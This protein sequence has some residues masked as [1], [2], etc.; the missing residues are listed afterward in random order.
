P[1]EA[2]VLCIVETVAVM[3]RSLD[4]LSG[5][6]LCFERA[7]GQKARA[8]QRYFETCCRVF[9]DELYRA[10][11]S[12][13]GAHHVDTEPRDLRQERLEVG[14][15]EGQGQIG[16]RLATALLEGLFEASSA[17][18]SSRIIPRHPYGFLVALLSRSN[19]HAVCRLPIGEGAPE[20]I[21]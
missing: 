2:D 6:A 16:E 13:E 19:A 4:T 1:A 21:L 9:L 10:A 18:S 7:L 3:Q 5:R 11:A 15:W 20:Y 17:F 8:T 14:L 12:K